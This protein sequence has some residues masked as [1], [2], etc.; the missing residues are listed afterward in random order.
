M[1]TSQLGRLE[2]LAGK[3]ADKSRHALKQQTQELQ[4]L[5]KH[6][7][8]LRSINHEYQQAPIGTEVAAPRLLA[9]RREFV[10][11]LAQKIDEL[12]VHREQALEKL[13][14]RA[15]ECKQFTAQHTAIDIV[16]QQRAEEY[17]ALVN[18]KDQQQ[19]DETAGR[20]HYQQ[21]RSLITGNDHE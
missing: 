12:D 21:Q 18:L 13:K 15:E 5:D 8:E 4:Q 9:I 1:S 2:K 3:R 17:N 19:L 11:Q 10:Q 14:E 16:N 20:Q 7:T 6:R